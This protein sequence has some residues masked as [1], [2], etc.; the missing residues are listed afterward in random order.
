MKKANFTPL[1]S[2]FRAAF[3]MLVLVLSA[4]AMNAQT[5]NFSTGFIPDSP[6]VTDF[7]TNVATIPAAPACP[8]TWIVS[9]VRLNITHTWASDL[10]IFLV[11]PS[12]TMY[13]LSTDN[14][15]NAGP[16]YIDVL[17]NLDPT[18]SPLPPA[19][20]NTALS[21]GPQ[22]CS[23]M[24]TTY[25]A[26][27]FGTDANGTAVPPPGVITQNIAA[28]IAPAVGNWII[29]IRDDT[30]GDTGTFVS[31]QLIFGYKTPGGALSA[32]V[33]PPA[34]VANSVATPAPTVTLPF[35]T[36]TNSCSPAP[37]V[38]YTISP[39]T[40]TPSAGTVTSA[41]VGVQFPIGTYTV[42]YC[43][44]DPATSNFFV[45][46]FP[47]VVTDGLPPTFTSMPVNTTISLGA[48]QCNATFSYPDITANDNFGFA[49]SPSRNAP[50][51]TWGP[52][53]NAPYTGGNGNFGA[54]F[55]IK[56]TSTSVMYIEGFEV[57]NANGFPANTEVWVTNGNT[58]V[59]NLLNPA[60]WTSLGIQSVTQKAPTPGGVFVGPIGD[61]NVR[62]QAD[63]LVLQPGES[64]GIFING[65]QGYTNAVGAAANTS[66]GPDMT[67]YTGNAVTGN[68]AGTV[69]GSLTYDANGANTGT[70]RRFNGRVLYRKFIPT[71]ALSH[72]TYTNN[73]PAVDV[74]KVG[75]TQTAG[76]PS[77]ATLPV[78]VTKYT[79]QAKDEA[80]NAKDSSF[81][82]TLTPFLAATQT[83]ACNDMTNISL[84]AACKASL[85]AG[86]F[87]TGGPYQCFDFYK[88]EL[89][90]GSTVLGTSFNGA[91]TGTA[92][93][94][95]V[96]QPLIVQVTDAVNPQNSCWGKVVLEDKLP[97][98][99][100]CPADLTIEC[101]ANPTPGATT[102]VPFSGAL[103]GVP[104]TAATGALAPT[105]ITVTGAPVGATIK[106]L[107]VSVNLTQND[108]FSDLR[109]TLVHPDGTILELA[110]NVGNGTAAGTPFG[111]GTFGNNGNYIFEM[112][113]SGAA[114]LDNTLAGAAG[115]AAAV[116]GKT[117]KPSGLP[118]ASWAGKPVNGNYQLVIQDGFPNAG[119]TIVRGFTINIISDVPFPS[120]TAVDACGS[121]TVK[122]GDAVQNFTCAQNVNISKIITRSF[123][124]TD[125]SGNTA[126]CA[127]KISV[128]RAKLTD[129]TF[130]I[131]RD[132]VDSPMLDCSYPAAGSI[133]AVYGLGA[134]YAGPFFDA[135][136]NPHPGVTGT[137][138]PS[139][140]GCNNVSVTYTDLKFNDVCGANGYKIVR[141]WKVVDWC[142]GTS[143]TREQIIK[144]G[145][146][147][148][149]VIS[150]VPTQQF[151][152]TTASSCAATL[153]LAKPTVTDNCSKT[154]TVSASIFTDLT[155]TTAV[156]TSNPANGLSF[157]D[158][159]KSEF[160][161][162]SESPIPYIVV[163]TAIDECGNAS[164]SQ[165]TL[166]VLD[167][168]PPV[169]VCHQTL[170]V[171][172]SLDGTATIP[173]AQFDE[174][175]Y[176]NCKLG[177]MH[178]KRMGDANSCSKIDLN[179][180][181]D[182]LDYV[183]L[184]QNG[185][186][187]AVA[188]RWDGKIDTVLAT[189]AASRTFSVANGIVTDTSKLHLNFATDTLI[190]W[191][192][193]LPL[194]AFNNPQVQFSVNQWIPSNF[195]FVAQTRT[196]T[197]KPTVAAPLRSTLNWPGVGSKTAV[198][199][200]Q[201]IYSGNIQYPIIY[202]SVYPYY[203]RT[204]S[205]FFRP[206]PGPSQFLGL[207]ENE[208]GLADDDN[209]YENEY[210]NYFHKDVKFC[211]ED[212]GNDT[213]MVAVKV[214]DEVYNFVNYNPDIMD[215][216]SDPDDDTK[217]YT[218]FLVPRRG[219]ANICMSR[220]IIEDKLPPIIFAESNM[221]VCSNNADA[222]AWLNSHKPQLKSL[223]S[224]PSATNPGYFDNCEAT[225]DFTDANS[226]DN[227]GNGTITRTWTATDKGGRKA[228][229][230]QT[231]MSINMSAYEVTFPANKDYTCALGGNVNPTGAGGTG[232]PKITTV[233]GSCPLVGVEYT[234]EIFDVVPGACY[235]ILRTWKI[236]NW[237]QINSSAGANTLNKNRG[238]E[239]GAGTLKFS[240]IDPLTVAISKL[241][242]VNDPNFK[243]KAKA[244]A[245]LAATCN[246]YDSDGYMEYT[247]IIKV[248]DNDAPILTA[249]TV[250]V[251]PLGKDCKVT[252]TA[253]KGSATDCTK[254]TEESVAIYKKGAAGSE[255]LVD[256]YVFGASKSWDFDATDKANY[257][258]RYKASDKC[259]NFSTADVPFSTSDLK[260]PT[261]VC[262]T[263][264]SA[265]IMPTAGTVMLMA[266]QFNNGS[267]DNCTEASKLKFTIES[268]ASTSVPGTTA[269]AD[270]FI[271]LAC[272]GPK[273]IRLWVTDAAG[274]SDYC[275]TFVDLQVNMPLAPGITVPNCSTASTA[276]IAGEVKTETDKTVEG[277]MMQLGG[278][279]IIQ[280][281]TPSTGY[282]NFLGLLPGTSY[283]VTPEMNVDPLN[284]V[285]TYDLVLISKHILNLQPF[286][287]PYKWVAA[288]INKNG[289]VTTFDMV[290]LRKLILHINSNFTSNTSWRF[291]DKSFAF[292]TTGNPIAA[293]FPEA[294][295]F[296]T[297]AADEQADFIG[298]KIG[299]INGSAK[300]SSKD[301][302]S[303]RSKGTINV[304]V[305]EAAVIAG[306]EVKVTFKAADIASIEG[307]QFTMNYDKAG[308]ELVTIEGDKANF[309]IIEEGVITTSWNGSTKEESLFTLVFKAKKDGQLSKMVSLNSRITKSEAYT[310]NADLMDIALQFNGAKSVAQFELYQNTPNP[311]KGSTVIGFNLPK[312]EFAKVTVYDM[313]GRTL[314]VVEGD[315]TKGYNEVSINDIQATGVL[316]YKLETASNVATKS[317]IIVE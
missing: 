125:A 284:G 172:L 302:A 310:N 10:D 145:D 171:S 39:A 210:Y 96:G 69:F 270:G 109:I 15:G 277:V 204:I 250:T 186:L 157:S 303:D 178:V 182:V 166:V 290:E 131:D 11:S 226:I 55:N 35:P 117:W 8:G 139:G 313:T 142:A 31:G 300:A 62:L 9:G 267:Y 151:A 195:N 312:A 153:T 239:C 202:T 20:P 194:T 309:G 141:T 119:S 189:L 316:Q 170:K 66:V 98:I 293:T 92:L 206:N 229:A 252:V 136:G 269:P 228:T 78:G 91:Y 251:K 2:S 118:F 156:G 248:S 188:Q 58:Y 64:K 298:V 225:I 234:D 105:P 241:T 144:V 74:P 57:N 289:S 274:N 297:L 158:V 183:G 48:G 193:P 70:S 224:Y 155:L 90:N 220:V 102:S 259:G 283:S 34:P 203:V 44:T 263:G 4:F 218:D 292:P 291:V 100:T 106:K 184:G 17:I 242:D 12:G 7:T 87:L 29:R 192:N 167:L 56:N 240:N 169:P 200:I 1:V 28:P 13:A 147:I 25:S 76:L 140:G 46:T 150:G 47:V 215:L 27:C 275:E 282:F 161:A 18:K 287:S 24:G 221:E 249:G 177:K 227:C 185:Q 243:F 115:N 40:A 63:C 253:T 72:G 165:G 255:T 295:N 5:Y 108:W 296:Q 271:T 110:K 213:L 238:A 3:S 116:S 214:W 301:A 207:D 162:A 94:T 176:D 45:T 79:F 97:P 217:A 30:G 32:I 143:G 122:S 138:A 132:G 212:L 137:P 237:C 168:I 223:T 173:A 95:L 191:Y 19:L 89:K 23:S 268:P 311:F 61:Y 86:N 181:G 216:L 304:S 67:I 154:T 256:T 85:T 53:A 307:Y 99:I 260:K 235:K 247:Q 230:T 196:L 88:V 244:A 264:L 111:A 14:G 211:C 294:K 280:K 265:E 82:V 205:T 179:K 52:N 130:P 120:A 68:L 278:S 107:G 101:S 38:T 232:E 26:D 83:L 288:D 262:F 37:V 286:N 160:D 113:D 219:N 22:V 75:I 201:N 187:F 305:D 129:V 65:A 272:K 233:A 254:V 273:A 71:I 134:A 50:A 59:G 16:G 80:G 54:A 257:V 236:I 6:N 42:T 174:G 43:V 279:S 41:G 126:K 148:A 299:D 112:D 146:M 33:T 60:A 128:R 121:A 190:T 222:K 149:P 159:P 175:S 84:D 231:V 261:P 281:Y 104:I 135:N 198:R 21:S 258:A 93:N 317:M 306:N 276:A 285:S 73:C 245:I 208:N 51:S 152:S 197:Y 81:T 36:V 308:L 49:N 133:P 123:T 246:G 314:K 209:Y 199:F 180:D 114:K 315:F 124:A 103:A 266:T 163:Y 77:G 164:T 127:F